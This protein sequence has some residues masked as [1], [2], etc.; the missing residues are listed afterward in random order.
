MDVT[1]WNSTWCANFYVLLPLIILW[2]LLP[3]LSPFS[4]IRYGYPPAVYYAQAVKSAKSVGLGGKLGDSYF[5]PLCNPP[6]LQYIHTYISYTNP[7]TRILY[8]IAKWSWILTPWMLCLSVC[9]LI[10]FFFSISLSLSSS[11]QSN[12]PRWGFRPNTK[13]WWPWDRFAWNCR[14]FSFQRVEKVES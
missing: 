2:S 6:A 12:S 9:L 3:S 13:Y 8:L 1:W 7:Q 5:G 11:L 4:K 14:Q 10:F